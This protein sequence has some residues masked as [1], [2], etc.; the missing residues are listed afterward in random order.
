MTAPIIIQ[1]RRE[2]LAL[3]KKL[4]SARNALRLAQE[5]AE[6]RHKHMTPE[7][8][9]KICAREADELHT[10]ASE[11]YEAAPWN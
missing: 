1:D 5:V 3:T 4:F 8:V 7:A 11:I 2:M 9:A 6:G 10:L